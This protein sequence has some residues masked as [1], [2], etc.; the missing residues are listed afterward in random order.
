MKVLIKWKLLLGKLW[1]KLPLTYDK[2]F[3]YMYVYSRKMYGDVQLFS[4][5]TCFMVGHVDECRN[6]VTNVVLHLMH[7]VR[8][9]RYFFLFNNWCN[10]TIWQNAFFVVDKTWAEYLNAIIRLMKEFFIIQLCV[11]YFIIAHI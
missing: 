2:L 8:Y 1:W 7:K 11:T 5:S 9:M 10:V 4:I 3:T 6:F